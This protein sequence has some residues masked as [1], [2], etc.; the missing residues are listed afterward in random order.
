[1][2]NPVLEKDSPPSTATS[3]K[4]L[5]III[6]GV[7]VVIVLAILAAL[8]GP[9]LLG[10]QEPT[11][12]N[13]VN[14]PAVAKPA[15]FTEFR[16]DKVGFTLSYPSSWTK[17]PTQDPQVLLLAANGPQDSFLV[18]AVEL[19]MQI[20]QQEIPAAKQLTD[21]IVGANKTAKMLVPP[22]QIELGGLPGYWYFYSFKD[23]TNGQQG[24]HSHFFLFKGNTMLT[25][26]FQSLPIEK[27]QASA[28]TFDQIT[29][30]F[31]VL[32]K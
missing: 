9:R 20:G 19:P 11:Q 2:T 6:A 8:Y 1:M 18:R 4:R 31:R 7:V 22:K 16:N 29:A 17:L 5:L 23:E 12:G 21:Q 15:G 24:A 26:V 10:F 3:K 13:P 30:S 25:F 32:P 28:P 27:F 14:S